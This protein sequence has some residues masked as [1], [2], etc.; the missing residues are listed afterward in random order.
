M[1]D[2]FAVAQDWLACSK[3]AQGYLVRLWRRLHEH[4][5]VRKLCACGQAAGID[6]NCDVVAF[7]NFYKKRAQFASL[8]P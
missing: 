3:V 4:Q 5:A 8:V 6:N 2:H 1:P 7:V